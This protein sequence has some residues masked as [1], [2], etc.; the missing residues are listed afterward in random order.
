MSLN[1]VMRWLKPREMVF[2]DLLDE[3]AGNVLASAQLF[4]Q[5]LRSGDSSTWAD[6]RRQMKDL[7]HKG[8]ELTHDILDRLNLTF[9]TPL[10][11][12]DIMELAHVLDDV[13]DKLDAVAERFVLYRIETVLPSALELSNLAVEGAVEVVV[14]I[15]SL[16]TMSDGKEISRRIR[17]VHALENQADAL[18]HAALAQ[19]FDD[20]KDPILLIK[21]KEILD[22]LEQA[23][24]DIKRVA[25]VV[26]STMMKNA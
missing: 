18:Y 4:D 13:V 3:A 7:E 25:Q 26:G 24:D 21:W 2:F 22:I 15:R 9:V 23:T 10:E 17:H 16:R 12:E 6:L 11:R 1:A 14:L 19:I 8:D 5:G 20:P